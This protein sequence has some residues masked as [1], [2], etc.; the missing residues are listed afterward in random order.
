MFTAIP[1]WDALHPMIVHFPIALLLVAPI[2]V[3]L[4]L[5]LP[6]QSKGLFISAVVLMALGTISTYLAVSTGEA[7]GEIAEKTAGLERVLETHE[8]LA[9]TTRLIFTAL[10]II[11]AAI[12]FAPSLFKRSLTRN[13]SIALNVAFLLFYSAGGLVLVNVAHEGG[14]LVHEFG[15]RAKTPTPTT[16]TTS[17]P[18]DKEPA[19]PNNR[20]DENE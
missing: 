17:K 15:V 5:L 10:T 9:E 18:S 20:H 1:S 14:R 7:A 3:I 11:F 19:K 4:G 2:L 13:T 16:A 6:R 12:V 8:G